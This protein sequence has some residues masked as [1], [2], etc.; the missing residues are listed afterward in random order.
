MGARKD[1]QADDMHAFVDRGADDL[2]RRRADAGIDHVEACVARAHRDLFRAV[3]VAVEAGLA[4]EEL[5]AGA[6]LVGDALHLAAHLVE[7]AADLAGGRGDARRRAVFAEDAAQRR[8]PFAGR[9]AGLGGGD[10][11]SMMLRPS[12][13]ARSTSA[14]AFS[15]FLASRLSRHA[16]SRAICSASTPSG[17]T[18]MASAGGERRGL[19]LGELVDADDGL[20]AAFDLRQTARVALDEAAFHVADLDATAPP[21]SS[22][23]LSSAM[24]SAFRPRP[25]WRSPDCRRRCRH[26]RAGR[27]HRP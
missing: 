25:S 16:L 1:R 6:D 4:D 3:R 24:A 22:I 13:A 10:G 14:R 19:G 20:L 18:M 11:G 26:I 2:G 21:S 5:G 17:T 15:A 8:T 7:L 27:S 23:F 12:L 9:H